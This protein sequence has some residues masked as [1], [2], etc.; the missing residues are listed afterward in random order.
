MSPTPLIALPG[1]LLEGRSLT[2]MLD[3]AATEVSILGEATS[4][5]EEVDRLA[6]HTTVPAIWLGH[7][8]GGIVALHLA[9]RH[10]TLV[11]ALV[12]L[13]GN[14]RAGRDTNE[15]RRATQWSIA[16]SKGLAALAR[17]ELAP[18][19]GLS[20]D[21][22]ADEAWTASLAAQ[23]EAVGMRRFEHQLNYARE[24]P[25]LLAPLKQ[26]KCPVLALSAELD[27]LCPPA[28]S[29][30]LLTL[31]L[32]P[33]RATHHTLAGAGH[34]FPMQQPHWAAEHLRSFLTSLEASTL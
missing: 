4:L 29:D 20:P 1:T 12:L 17:Q 10:P 18:G 2:A 11:V 21:R 27:A 6:A 16:Q 25:G 28:Q 14:A 8:L 23:A 24:R 5:N 34:L 33:C 7:S 15:E 32:P 3:G 31:V 19:Y 13:A 9:Q 30:E 22:V 26:L